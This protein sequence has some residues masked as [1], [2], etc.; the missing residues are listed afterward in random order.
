M[1]IKFEI[2]KTFY[3]RE[4]VELFQDDNMKGIRSK[5]VIGYHHL[6][7]VLILITTFILIISMA[8]P[9]VTV[10]ADDNDDE[11]E[12]PEWYQ[13]D[14]WEY[15]MREE[16]ME[17]VTYLTEVKREVIDERGEVT[18]RDNQTGDKLY[19]ADTYVLSELHGRTLEEEDEDIGDVEGEFHY[20]KEHLSPVYTEPDQ[21]PASFYFPPIE[22]MNFPLSIGK[23]W[24]GGAD[25]DI[26][27]FEVRDPD[28]EEAP[29]PSRKVHEYYGVVEERV[30]KE[31]DAGIFD[32]F[33]INL[34]VLGEDLE[35][36]VEPLELK[37]FEIYYAPEVKNIIHRDIYETKRVPDDFGMG[38]D[39][40]W[41]EQTGTETLVR[42][43]LQDG[44]AQTDDNDY[45][46][47][48]RT[49]TVILAIIGTALVYRYK[50]DS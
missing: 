2:G 37:R 49:G 18:V 46:P 50:K 5:T 20:T 32:A 9:S 12:I 39:V 1:R 17:D 7:S 45:T 28:S 4:G 3:R 6:L 30:T 40:V 47:F 22:E 24:T 8:V 34:T 42:Y 26:Y 48:L 23:N 16:I 13:G 38:D 41:E 11:A 36:D 25:E 35:K 21:A 43:E 29:E 31:V 15:E 33:L 14:V 44:P 27:F 10:T 19:E